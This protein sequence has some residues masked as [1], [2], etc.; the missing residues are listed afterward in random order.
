MET[1]TE[2]KMETV[3]EETKKTKKK[4]GCLLKSE[5]RVEGAERWGIRR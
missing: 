3:R 4:R 5:E 2:N 1:K